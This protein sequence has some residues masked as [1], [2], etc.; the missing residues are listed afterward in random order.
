VEVAAS[1][2]SLD[3][4]DFQGASTEIRG[5]VD[6]SVFP[7]G[8]LHA[9]QIKMTTADG[10]TGTVPL[11]FRVVEIDQA[12]PKWF[13]LITIL[14]STVL[15]TLFLAPNRRGEETIKIQ[16]RNSDTGKASAGTEQSKVR[17]ELSRLIPGTSVSFSLPPIIINDK[18]R[19]SKFRF[20]NKIWHPLE[21]QL[22]SMQFNGD[23][24]VATME[25]ANHSDQED[26]LLFLTNNDDKWYGDKIH[27]RDENGKKYY[28]LKGLENGLARQWNSITNEFVIPSNSKSYPVIRFPMVDPGVRTLAFI[29]PDI[30]GQQGG[31]GWSDI[32]AMIET[33]NS[34]KRDNNKSLLQSAQSTF[35]LVASGDNAPESIVRVISI[36]TNR[37]G[38][39]E[40][41]VVGGAC[42]NKAGAHFAIAILT[43]E[44][45]SVGDLFFT[46]P[47]PSP[48]S[49]FA[50]RRASP[51]EAEKY[52]LCSWG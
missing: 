3:R 15:L 19:P 43:A 14:I 13:P 9:G 5:S 21:L 25:I 30:H 2:I 32:N 1:G 34:R 35:T 8:S 22:I 37:L 18:K 41:A 36:A 28:A 17:A 42:P 4:Y 24:I 10:T 11:Q 44:K 49:D 40:V 52:R 6:A 39:M 50:L 16:Q 33:E 23:E 46:V 47:L 27:L 20:E 26:M 7:A 29:S 48:S 51:S 38:D 45:V 12:G 31:W